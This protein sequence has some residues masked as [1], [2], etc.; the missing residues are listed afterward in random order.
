VKSASSTVDAATEHRLRHEL[1]SPTARAATPRSTTTRSPSADRTPPAPLT[2]LAKTLRG[3]FRQI[4]T[5]D[6]ARHIAAQWTDHRFTE[7]DMAAWWRHGLTAHDYATARQL[8]SCGIRPHHLE[9]VIQGNAVKT[10]LRG[11]RSITWV[12]GLLRHGGHIDTP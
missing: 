5:D 6:E 3:T 1:R 7:E 8:D 4:Q 12:A 2:G 9:L 11:G 10:L